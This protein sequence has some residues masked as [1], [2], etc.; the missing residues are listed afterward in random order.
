MPGGALSWSAST[1]LSFSVLAAPEHAGP[2]R[3]A[4]TRLKSRSVNFF[5]AKNFMHRALP[6]VGVSVVQAIRP[7]MRDPPGMQAYSIVE[8]LHSVSSR[9][10]FAM[11]CRCGVLLCP[12]NRTA[13]PLGTI[14]D[15]RITAS[16]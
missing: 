10:G 6:P 5:Q 3:A 11:T 9:L 12:L 15:I 7:L 1:P 14:L 16:Q 13:V 8:I 2:F 4:S